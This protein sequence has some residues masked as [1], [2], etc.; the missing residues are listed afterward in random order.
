MNVLV[1][2]STHPA[3]PSLL[4]ILTSILTPH[5]L[6]Q[7]LAPSQLSVQEYPWHTSCAL[8]ILLSPP[9]DHP[10]VRK[11]L[12][13]GGRILAFGVS[14]RKGS[15]FGLHD[16]NHDFGSLSAGLGLGMV[17]DTTIL[18][19]ADGNASLYIS[20]S[21]AT[22]TSADVSIDTTTV[23]VSRLPSDLDP[24]DAHILGRYVD[25]PAGVLSQSGLVAMWNCIPPL[26]DVL[27]SRSMSA[28]GLRFSAQRAD[29]DLQPHILP[30]L[31]LARP[32]SWDVQHRV[33]EALL[34]HLRPGSAH[35][36]NESQ[37]K[38]EPFAFEDANDDF[39]FHFPSFPPADRTDHPILELIPQNSLSNPKVKHVLVPPKPLT[40][41][42]EKIYTP[43]FSSSAFFRAIDEF[44]SR[45]ENFD[46]SPDSWRIGD[47]FMYGE[48][49]SSTQTMFDKNPS[50]LRALPAPIVSLA[51]VQLAG[52]GRG[53]NSWLSPAGCMQMSLKIRVGLKGSSSVPGPSIRPSIR[54]SN[55]VFI[56]YLFALAVVDACQALDPNSQWA[57]KVRLKW[58]NDIYGLFPS[59]KPLSK[60]EPRKIG[61]ILVNT[62]FGGG[63]ADVVIGSGLNVLN[64]PPIAS[65]AQLAS[66]G[67]STPGLSVER[68]A[69]AVLTSFDRLWSSFLER[70]EQGF[71]PF[72]DHYLRSW[73][74]TDQLVTLTNRT[75]H[76]S[77]RIVGITPDHGLL[78]TVPLSGGEFID[79]QPDGNSF[80]MMKGLISTKKQ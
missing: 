40:S 72:M 8:L 3:T 71:Q 68:V 18:R 42:D 15:L 65:L 24:S 27:L 35:R 78:R 1:Y 6:P 32:D 74:H 34:D 28:L 29:P 58:P 63:V 12:E 26:P 9:T 41:E 25:A 56:Q 59:D 46:Q 21:T 23:S 76:R 44:R 16:S 10:P 37:R 39:H 55:L 73:L 54:P 11:Y 31:L 33:V 57:H 38:L 69:A 22:G 2:P 20:F 50:F 77:V 53:G 36:D 14:V 45:T 47:A 64:E 19:V 75:P 5:Y 17:K 62:S 13:S 80:D 60:P 49:V 66:S 30:Q 48:V 7:S 67:T 79:L 43:Q 51:T 70:E 52:R 61:G 4:Q